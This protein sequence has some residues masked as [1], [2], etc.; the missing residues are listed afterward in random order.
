MDSDTILDNLW[1]LTQKNNSDEKIDK[2]SFKEDF[3]NN[4]YNELKAFS[5]EYNNINDEFGRTLLIILKEAESK[6]QILGESKGGSFSISPG[7]IKKAVKTIKYENQFI[8]G[9]AEYNQKK[10]QNSEDLKD[11]ILTSVVISNMIDNYSSL[12]FDEKRQLW[13]RSFS[14]S[15]REFEEL[16]RATRS[17]W[18]NKAK[19]A[20]EQGNKDEAN[21]YNTAIN[22]SDEAKKTNLDASQIS[23]ILKNQDFIEMLSRNGIKPD[24]FGQMPNHKQTEIFKRYKEGQINQ[25]V[26]NHEQVKDFLKKC[27]TREE[28][29]EILRTKEPEFY[30]I[31]AQKYSEMDILDEDIMKMLVKEYDRFATEQMNSK[32]SKKGTNIIVGD[33]VKSNMKSSQNE[34]STFDKKIIDRLIGS[35]IQSSQIKEFLD[36]NRKDSKK[37]LDIMDE[38]FPESISEQQFLEQ[39]ISDSLTNYQEYFQDFDDEMVEAMSEMTPEEIIANIK[40]DFDDMQNKGEIAEEIRKVL[41]VMLESITEETKGILLDPVKRDTFFVKIQSDIQ[42]QKDTE[43]IKDSELIEIFKQASVDLEVGKMQEQRV[44]E[45]EDNSALLENAHMDTEY[46]VNGVAMNIDEQWLQFFQ[47]AQN[48][49]EDLE[50]AYENYKKEQEIEEIE[51]RTTQEEKKEDKSQ[52]EQEQEVVVV[53]EDGTMKQPAEEET[54][55]SAETLEVEENEFFDLTDISTLKNSKKSKRVAIVEKDEA[56]NLTNVQIFKPVEFFKQNEVT[57]H[58]FKEAVSEIASLTVDKDKS[59]IGKENEEEE[60]GQE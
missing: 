50:E 26:V 1:E 39:D 43:L 3:T 47:D 48:R 24:E 23:D 52:G 20:T 25:N 60:I 27:K 55:L 31:Y 58:E 5:N 45:V 54:E 36:T 40:D 34:P 4:I 7:I 8:P 10:M 57:T 37:T 41:D 38:V 32:N 15:N 28:I 51:A 16:E 12:S 21:Y 46:I 33:G 19:K 30:E 56:G 17:D 42:S 22:A 14:L 2:D 49:G 44:E 11:V 6:P 13:D 35:D 53:E 9:K 59:D 29:E 18:E